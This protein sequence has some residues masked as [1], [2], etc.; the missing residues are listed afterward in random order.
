MFRVYPELDLPYMW[1]DGAV[2]LG[3]PGLDSME[4]REQ[5]ESTS[6]N[7]LRIFIE[8][9]DVITISV[10]GNNLLTPVIESTFALYP[11]FNSY[12]GTTY[13]EKLMSAIVYYG[14]TVWN[15]KLDAF[16]ASALSSVPT[17]L[18]S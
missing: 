7:A 13:E 5:L 9:A 14:E 17:T 16:A 6:P 15:M 2:N 18:G 4:L 12:P 10:G 1:T 3:F 8:Q 11:D